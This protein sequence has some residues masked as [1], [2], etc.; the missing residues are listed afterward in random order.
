[1]DA[2]RDIQQEIISLTKEKGSE[3]SEA[4]QESVTALNA[5]I[6]AINEQGQRA[7]EIVSRMLEHTLL[8]SQELSNENV[9]SFMEETIAL[10]LQQASEKS[11][12]F[13]FNIKKN[14]DKTLEILPMAAQSLGKVISILLINSL[15]SL[16]K[17]KAL[18]GD[19]YSPAIIIETKNL[20]EVYQIKVADNGEGILDQNIGKIFTPFFTTKPTGKGIGLGLSLSH[21]IIVQQ[22]GGALTFETKSGEFAEFTISL[23]TSLPQL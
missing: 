12:T 3:S 11:P 18:L 7:N 4:I 22:H 14:L 13:T 8:E 16:M 19:S 10:F 9:I 6:E 5:N 20:G 21:N 17:K 1:M 23:P 15:E 2:L